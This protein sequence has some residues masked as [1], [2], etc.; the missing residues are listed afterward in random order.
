MNMEELADKNVGGSMKKDLEQP[1]PFLKN[2]QNWLLEGEYC[3]VYDND[4]PIIKGHV[5][6][7]PKREIEG[8]F[9]MIPEE[10]REVYELTVQYIKK[11]GA[12]G[13]N[14]GHNSGNIAGQ[15]VAHIHFHIFPHFNNSPGMPKDGYGAAFGNLP[16]YYKENC[17]E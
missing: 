1:S 17:D 15:S 11:C 4:Y 5:L 9:D 3:F 14:I 6:I 16:D 13:F 12:I 8:F 10:W 7:V 2:K